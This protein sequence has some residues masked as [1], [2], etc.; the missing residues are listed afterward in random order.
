MLLDEAVLKTISYFDLFDYPL[1]RAEIWKYLISEKINLFETDTVLTTL[2]KSGR[3]EEKNG[4]IFFPGRGSIAFKRESRYRHAAR[5]WR[6]AHRWANFFSAIPGVALVG[7]GNTLSYG[8]A[9]DSSDIDFFII[10]RRG[11]I[12]RTRFFAA[13]MAA[14][15][16]LRPTP[17]TGRDKICLSFFVDEDNLNLQKFAI[18]ASPDIYLAFWIGQMMPLYGDVRIYERFLSENGWVKEI[19]PNIFG[20]GVVSKKNNLSK[21]IFS[22]LN[23]LPGNFLK[24]FQS[25]HFPAALLLAEKKRDGAV[26]ISDEVLKFHLN[27]RR[28]E[29]YNMWNRRIS[30][31]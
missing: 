25:R 4:L 17:K 1:T 28:G 18:T 9:K 8:N 31:T 29:I 26:C 19:L 6:R 14:L 3:L 5:K 27:D 13:G 23:L 10:V 7:I 11:T 12:W 30:N 15:F 22:P 2:V 20:C 24:K 21:Y 16:R